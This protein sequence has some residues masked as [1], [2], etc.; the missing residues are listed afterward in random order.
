MVE[1]MQTS[2]FANEEVV[3]SYGYLSGYKPKDFTEQT[4]CLREL[5]P[6]IGYAN[7]D[8]LT[9]IKRKEIALPRQA[10]GWFAIPNWMKNQHLF[11]VTYSAALQKVLDILKQKHNGNLSNYVDSGIDE[12]HIRQSARTQ[13]FFQNLLG[14]QGNPDI[15][16]VPA[17]F[18]TLHRGRSV[19]RARKVFLINEVGL[20]SFAI[21]IMLLTHPE[22]LQQ[23]IDL[24]IDCPGDEFRS[25]DK[26]SYYQ[27]PYFGFENGQIRFSTSDMSGADDDFGSA[28]AF[29]PKQY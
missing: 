11:G 26:G 28:S 14:E 21:S 12:K 1:K 13:K 7:Q 5:F 19:Y 25:S 29:S 27:N 10:E 16:I 9:Q 15:L 18:G 17:Q 24:W 3:I 23:C 4:N 2:K 22:R 20:G 6:G 8:L